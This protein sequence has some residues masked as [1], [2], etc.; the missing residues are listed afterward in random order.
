MTKLT[1]IQ[2][3]KNIQTLAK[4]QNGNMWLGSSDVGVIILKNNLK[5]H[6]FENGVASN[7]EKISTNEGICSNCVNT[8]LFNKDVVWFISNNGINEVKVD[9]FSKLL[10]TPFSK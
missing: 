4:D 3:F 7:F 9:I 8:I 10:A 2:L 6:Y 1:T 5:V